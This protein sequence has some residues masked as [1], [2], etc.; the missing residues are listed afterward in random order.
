MGWKKP[1]SCIECRYW[2]HRKQACPYQE[3]IY[4]KYEEDPW[5]KNTVPMDKII[6]KQ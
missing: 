3:C 1:K 5:K 4:D 2:N 6:F